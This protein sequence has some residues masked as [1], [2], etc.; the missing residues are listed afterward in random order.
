MLHSE[1]PDALLSIVADELG[2]LLG[3]ALLK[4]ALKQL[5]LLGIL[6]SLPCLLVQ[7]VDVIESH[8]SRLV[9]AFS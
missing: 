3:G 4:L 2:V 8:F 9:Q 7:L 1:P 5:L 6:A